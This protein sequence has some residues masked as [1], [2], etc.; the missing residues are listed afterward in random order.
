MRIAGEMESVRR[1]ESRRESMMVAALAERLTVEQRHL[2][3]LASLQIGQCQLAAIGRVDA[4]ADFAALDHV[5]GVTRVAGTEQD[6]ARV[7]IVH[8]HERAQLCR[9]LIVEGFKQRNL[10]QGLDRHLKE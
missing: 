4:D 9:R 2:P 6:F 1:E 8:F 10:A 3:K 5:H 7:V